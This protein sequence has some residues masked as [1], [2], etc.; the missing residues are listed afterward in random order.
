MASGSL[1]SEP[2]LRLGR[3]DD[4]PALEA[5]IRLSVQKLQAATYSDAQREAALGPVFG[6][7]RDLLA[8][9]TCWVAESEGE[10]VACGSWSWRRALFGG[11]TA[12]SP[13]AGG[14]GPRLDPS[15]EAARIRAFFVHPA[16]ARRGLG[17]ALLLRCESEAFAHGFREAEL[18][19]TLAG[20]P[21]YAAGGYQVTAR[22]EVP[23][24]NGLA[25]PVVK[26]R[27][28]LAQSLLVSESNSR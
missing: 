13:E 7:D 4:V 10:I 17:R 18:V 27:R 16:W 3:D 12:R 8:D 20:E 11:S 15:R 2:A 1:P 25:L 6:V 28:T 9:G 22:Y 5:L 23:L 19:A 14:Q 24:G 26:M 21:F